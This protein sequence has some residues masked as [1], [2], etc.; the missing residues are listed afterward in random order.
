MFE[1]Q[2]G[3]DFAAS[4]AQ[5]FGAER[6]TAGEPSE[7]DFWNGPLAAALIAFRDFE[8]LYYEDIPQVRQLHIV[9]PTFGAIVIFGVLVG[10]QLVELADFDDDPDYWS[11]IDD[12]L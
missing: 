10:E 1:V 9:D 3:S 2:I 7:Y 4:I 12:S 5:R 6:G 11:A 8:S